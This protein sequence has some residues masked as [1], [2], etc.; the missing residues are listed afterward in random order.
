MM[1]AV[2]RTPKLVDLFHK[3]ERKRMIEKDIV[4]ADQAAHQNLRR[5]NI[6]E[7]NYENFID[8]LSSSVNN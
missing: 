5:C 3:T 1:H 4:L 8:E 2:I 6:N 7:T